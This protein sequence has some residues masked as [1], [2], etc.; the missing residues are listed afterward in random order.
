M[1]EHIDRVLQD[2]PYDP[3]TL[4]VRLTNGADGRDVI[5]MRVDLGILQL[6]TVHRPDGALP[7][8][9]LTMYDYLVDQVETQGEE[10]ALSEEECGEIDREFVQYYHRRVCWLKLQ[11]YHRAA[12]DA[13]HTLALMDFCRQHS[14]DDQWTMTHEQYR[15]FVMFHRIQAQA[16]ALLEDDGPQTAVA[17]IENGLDELRSVFTEHGADEYFDEDEL[18]LRLREMRE[19]LFEQFNNR[20]RLSRA[21]QDAVAAERF[22]EAAEIRD[23]L[24]RLDIEDPQ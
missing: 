16:L 21:L 1:H 19:S 20:Q 15:P 22:E 24:A 23:E 17:C 11:Q 9:E 18:V 7:F 5:Q 14:L 12:S 3:S 10:F 8:G 4:S 6:E 13:N 2:W